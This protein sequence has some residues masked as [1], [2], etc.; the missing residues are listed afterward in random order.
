M[1]ARHLILLK[2]FVVLVA[3]KGH[4]QPLFETKIK[5]LLCFYFLV[6]LTTLQ[7]YSQSYYPVE[8]RKIFA[9]RLSV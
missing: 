5:R 4:Q 3:C 9:V 7:C 1:F 8:E 2:G 6:V